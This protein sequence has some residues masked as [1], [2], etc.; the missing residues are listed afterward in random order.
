MLVIDK[1]KPQSF[2]EAKSHEDSSNWLRAMQDEM[3]SLQKNKTYELVELLEGRKA[4]KNKWVY[5]F[6]RDNSGKLVKYKAQLV[7]KDFRQK[8]GV[9]FIEILSLIMKI[10][11]I[12]VT[13]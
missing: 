10:T 11:S 7:V 8:K 12:R 13:L 9:D 2:L 4:L 3:D 1:G 6:K 5:K